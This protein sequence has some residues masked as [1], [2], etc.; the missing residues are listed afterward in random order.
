MHRCRARQDARIQ[1]SRYIPGLPRNVEKVGKNNA[2]PAGASSF[3]AI[4]A[5]MTGPFAEERDVMSSS[6]A[7]TWSASFS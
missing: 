1:S 6:V 3:V 4:T 5:S 2:Y 7:T